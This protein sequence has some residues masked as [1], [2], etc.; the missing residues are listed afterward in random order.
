MNTFFFTK[1]ARI[2]NGARAASSMNGAR[3]T[4]KRK[5]LEQF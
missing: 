1:E 5:K 3:K 4:Y 2:Y